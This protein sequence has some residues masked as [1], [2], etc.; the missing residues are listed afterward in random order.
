MNHGEPAP[1]FRTFIRPVWFIRRDNG[2][3]VPVL[4]ADELPSEVHL[5]GVP[6]S[7][8]LDD[9]QGM[10]FL[11]N[12]CHTGQ[13]YSLVPRDQKIAEAPTANCAPPKPAQTQQP[14][15]HMGVQSRASDKQETVAADGKPLFAVNDAIVKALPEVVGRFNYTG[16][17]P[18]P[19]SGKQPDQT[20]KEYCTYWIKTGGCDFTQQGC[21]FKHEMPD[22]KTLREKVGI[23]YIPKWW[24]DKHPSCNPLPPTWMKERIRYQDAAS[25]KLPPFQHTEN[26]DDADVSSSSEHEQSRPSNVPHNATDVAG[27]FHSSSF[28]APDADHNQK[29][30]DDG[31]CGR[32]QEPSSDPELNYVHVPLLDGQKSHRALE[33]AFR[34]SNPSRH[35]TG[36]V[37]EAKAGPATFDPHRRF[38]S[39]PGPRDP[40]G[41]S[42]PKKEVNNFFKYVRTSSAPP[43]PN[44]P[45]LAPESSVPQGPR[46]VHQA[47]HRPTPTA[48]STA[49]TDASQ[50]ADHFDAGTLKPKPL[51]IVSKLVKSGPDSSRDL[52]AQGG[53]LSSRHAS[54]LTS[55]DGSRTHTQEHLLDLEIDDVDHGPLVKSSTSASHSGH[56]VTPIEAHYA[57]DNEADFEEL[58]LVS[59]HDSS[60]SIN[61]GSITSGNDGRGTRTR[62]SSLDW[63]SEVPSFEPSRVVES[64]R[65][66]EKSPKTGHVAPRGKFEKMVS[67]QKP[68]GGSSPHSGSSAGATTP[69]APR[70]R[71][72]SGG[73]RGGL[74]PAKMRR[75]A[76]AETDIVGPSAGPLTGP[77]S[78]AQRR[79]GKVVP[80]K[81]RRTKVVNH[82]Q[83]GQ[84]MKMQQVRVEV[85]QQKEV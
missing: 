57:I 11:G 59:E 29:A 52:A 58:I 43:P 34:T 80:I 2:N 61:S 30:K 47:V 21:M 4:A 85:K 71:K 60:S 64:A 42:P 9:A 45:V 78:E 75:P 33:R 13:T 3:Y 24:T 66:M 50:P 70:E 1:V 39:Y 82:G 28:K 81:I 17:P 35:A 19:P 74:R 68:V 18:L 6:R 23:N 83:G 53:R 54:H 46:T 73:A 8:N 41:R 7:I 55:S 36:P 26:G 65:R 79:E 63:D 69:A 76:V 62:S 77:K 67:R 20:K 44:S 37:G 14:E 38:P 16:Q 22:P 51:A 56:C 27:A 84:G 5:E 40:A 31:P 12:L 10:K 49:T 15:H 25:T 72:H 32:S 48:A